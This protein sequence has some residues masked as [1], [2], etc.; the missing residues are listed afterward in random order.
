LYTA[1]AHVSNEG[2]SASALNGA[3]TAPGKSSTGFDV[4]IKHSF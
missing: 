4:G 1:V 3:V 2:P